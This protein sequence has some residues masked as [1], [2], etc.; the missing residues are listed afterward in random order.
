MDLDT[1]AKDML[2][3]ETG[4]KNCLEYITKKI[5]ELDKFFLLTSGGA[6]DKQEESLPKPKY[7]EI[8]RAHV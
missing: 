2:N 6:R 7:I 1:L 4:Y 5:V 3:T 8:G